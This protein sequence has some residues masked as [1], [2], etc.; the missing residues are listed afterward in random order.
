MGRLQVDLLPRRRRGRAG[1]PQRT[2]DDPL[3]PR[4]GE[5]C[6]RRA[7]RALRH[8][9]R[10]RHRRRRRIGLRGAAA[11]AAPCRVAGADARRADARIVHRVRSARARRRRLHGPPVQ[12]APRRTR[13]RLG[14]RGTDVS[15]HSRHDGS[16]HGAALV[17]R[18][19]GCGSRRNRRQA[20]GHPVSARQANHVQDQAHSD[21]G[22]RRRR[23]P[24][25][26]SPVPTRSA[27]CYSG[28][29][30]TTAL[31]RRSA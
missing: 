13:R 20:T 21:G 24:R 4:A 11:A 17:L 15:R 10:D 9:R 27:R 28:S 22:L 5:R 12:R 18:V 3:L 2:P 30:K 31:S 14:R 23:I 6:H 7:A 29:S 8:R 1:Q 19:R 25:C 26:T 16:G